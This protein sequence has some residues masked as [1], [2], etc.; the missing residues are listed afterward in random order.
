M[1][2]LGPSTDSTQELGL[3]DE[4]ALLVLL[5]RLVRLI[6][7]PADR[8]LA[9]AAGDVAHNV[10]ARRHVALAGLAHFDVDDGVEEEGFAVLAAEVLDFLLASGKGRGGSGARLSQGLNLRG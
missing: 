5:T 7:L 4:L 10:A 9:L 8:L 3:Q 6:V 2:S 1:V